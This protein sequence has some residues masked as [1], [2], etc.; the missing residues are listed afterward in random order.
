VA[1]VLPAVLAL[2]INQV[3]ADEVSV[4]DTIASI[5][6]LKQGV[7]FSL[8]DSQINYLA[9]IELVNFKGFALE[10]GYAGRAKETGDK[11]VAVLSYDL[12][13]LDKYTSLPIL[14]YVEFRPGVYAGFGRLFGSQEFDY[15]VSATVLSIKF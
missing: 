3:K 12:L 2:P 1:L 10:G 8:A 9:T 4:I 5:P 13:S 14:K 15:G 6:G 11:L 7:A